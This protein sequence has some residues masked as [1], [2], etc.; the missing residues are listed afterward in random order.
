ME[1]KPSPAIRQAPIVQR[2]LEELS[3]HIALD[4]PPSAQRFLTAARNEFERLAEMPGLGGVWE[5]APHRMQ[6][7]RVWPITGFE[8][9]LVFYRPIS[10]G[11]EIVRVLHS[12]R[13][14]PT[15]FGK[16]RKPVE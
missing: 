13:D 12:A 9:Y 5:D 4:S 6:D 8:N 10:G 14:F 3:D 16:R 11:I 2:D 7:M 15:F 1:E